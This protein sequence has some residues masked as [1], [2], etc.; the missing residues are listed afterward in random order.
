MSRSDQPVVVTLRTPGA[1]RDANVDVLESS[2]FDTYPILWY[3]HYMTSET[4]AHAKH[5]RDVRVKTDP[6]F[7]YEMTYETADGTLAHFYFLNDNLSE[8]RH[9]AER[10]CSEVSHLDNGGVVLLFGR[11]ISVR[12]VRF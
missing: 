6:K 5:L 2:E 1:N 11:F 9:H 10:I 7:V 12:R 3:D 4:F 8:A